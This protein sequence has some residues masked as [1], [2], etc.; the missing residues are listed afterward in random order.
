[1]TTRVKPILPSDLTKARTYDLLLYLSTRLEERLEEE[2]PDA[3]EENLSDITTELL[4]RMDYAEE[5]GKED[6]PL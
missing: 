2:Y 5:A 3:W 4:R 6:V 1:M